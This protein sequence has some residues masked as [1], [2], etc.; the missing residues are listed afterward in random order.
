MTE[1]DTPYHDGFFA[2]HEKGSRESA[3]EIVP[4]VLEDLRPA[5][6]VDVGCG[7]G[8]WLVEFQAAGVAD[9]VGVD[10]D[11]VNRA[12][13]LIDPARFLAR[14]L[15]E[16]LVLDRRFEL[17][18]SLEV[19]EHLPPETAS[20]FVGSLTRLAPVVLFSGAIPYQ[21]GANH[22]NEQWPEYWEQQFLK[23][24][25][26]VV[27]SLRPRL[28]K[29][30]DIMP[31]YRQNLLY[32]VQRDRLAEYPALAGAFEPNRE[33]PLSFVLPEFYEF[34]QKT[35]REQLRQSM[36]HAMRLAVG[37]REINLIVFPDW[38]QPRDVVV[39]EIRSLL[40]AILSHP[41]RR[42]VTVVFY[43]RQ[44]QDT[45]LINPLLDLA[46]EI[47][48]PGGI[49]LPDGPGVAAVGPSFGLKEWEILLNCLQG[50][51]SLP[52]EDTGAIATMGALQLQKIP[53][54]RVQ[55]GGMLVE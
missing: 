53:S 11:Y 52:H 45:D 15:A 3:H 38:S 39:Q 30:A 23:Y 13:L 37:L 8:T 25:Y 16:P 55:A 48:R 32:F 6:I 51:I 22:V 43:A 24:E 17:A 27:D 36:C 7:I 31:W 40:T 28:R 41:D 20:T 33:T 5:S 10:G 2:L 35:S 42:R 54:A 49:P 34:R 9:F 4:L 12:N 1:T 26:V 46:C 14:D 50:R 29:R 47:V 19:A 21:G 18:V 44:Q